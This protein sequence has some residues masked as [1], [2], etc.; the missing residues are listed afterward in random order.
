M[1]KKDFVKT[2]YDLDWETFFHIKEPQEAW[3][4]FQVQQQTL[5]DKFVPVK[6]CCNKS[7]P[8]FSVKIKK[9]CKRKY[10][11]DR[12]RKNMKLPTWKRKEWHFVYKTLKTEVRHT[13]KDTD[14]AFI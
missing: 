3:N 6:K 7:K 12:Q 1:E 8:W 5:I 10:K 11:A 13:I 9:L 4:Y 14:T 2:F